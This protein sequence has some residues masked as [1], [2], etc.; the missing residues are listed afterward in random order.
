MRTSH[1]PIKV[2]FKIDKIVDGHATLLSEEIGEIRWPVEKLPKQ[3]SEGDTLFLAACE[4]EDCDHLT[5]LRELLE[6]LVS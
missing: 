4:N 2:A 3:Y 1:Q 6:E 5:H